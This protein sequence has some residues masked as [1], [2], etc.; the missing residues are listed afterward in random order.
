MK[1]QLSNGRPAADESGSRRPVIA[2]GQC[3]SNNDY[4]RRRQV[5]KAK[6]KDLPPTCR[7][8]SAQ[9]IPP[10]THRCQRSL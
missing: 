10:Y 5:F 1:N 3:I 7:V 9:N 6:T 8:G 4:S 2:A